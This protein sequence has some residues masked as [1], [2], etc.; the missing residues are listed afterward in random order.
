VSAL[1]DHR[2]DLGQA[3]V[4]PQ[5]SRGLA[6]AE[7]DPAAAGSV[8]DGAGKRHVVDQLAADRLDPARRLERPAPDQHAAAG[9]RR[10]PP[11]RLVDGG[12][13]IELQAKEHEG[14]DQEALPE[15]LAMQPDHQ[16]GEVDAFGL[17]LGDQAG[18]AFRSMHDVGIGQQ[19]V[20]GFRP[21]V[22]GMAQPL[23]DRP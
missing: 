14:R 18:E 11:C 3:L 10:R 9:G 12:K 6:K 19:D 7:P 21:D 1:R 22:R 15:G 16:R 4:A 2:P 20:R 5:A 13:R 17:A 8:L 23:V